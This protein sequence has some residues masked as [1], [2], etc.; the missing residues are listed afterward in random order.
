MIAR[1]RHDEKTPDGEFIYIVETFALDK[2]KGD[3][4]LLLENGKPVPVK[5]NGWRLKTPFHD[6]KARTKFREK[7]IRFDE[8]FGYVVSIHKDDKKWEL[9]G[10]AKA[11]EPA[12][13]EEEQVFVPE[14]EESL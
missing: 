10:R 1:R 4:E 2:S 12:D 14:E 8:E 13:L 11:V 6:G 3:T 7:A 9:A 5:F